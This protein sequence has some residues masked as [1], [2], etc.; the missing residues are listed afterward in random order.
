MLERGRDNFIE[1]K[2]K[3]LELKKVNQ[4]LTIKLRSLEEQIKEYMEEKN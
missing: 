1:Q 3:F 4:D 2:E